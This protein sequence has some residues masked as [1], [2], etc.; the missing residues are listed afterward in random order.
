MLIRKNQ[1]GKGELVATGED[2]F[3]RADARL[4]S[5]ITKVTRTLKSKGIES[6]YHYEDTYKGKDVIVLKFDWEDKDVV[7]K[8]IRMSSIQVIV[9]E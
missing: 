9:N 6:L 8:T 5:L 7:A 1:Q 4:V 3:G 2:K